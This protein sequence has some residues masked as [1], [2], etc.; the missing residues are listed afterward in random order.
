MVWGPQCQMQGLYDIEKALGTVNT[1][2]AQ[3]GGSAPELG[4]G[5]LSQ[6]LFG[7]FISAQCP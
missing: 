7:I 3:L 5:A 2:P 4:S 1:P 6:H